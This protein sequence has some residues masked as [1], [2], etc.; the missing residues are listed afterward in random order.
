MING[1]QI[2]LIAVIISCAFNSFGYVM[3]KLAHNR[4]IETSEVSLKTWQW[5][6]AILVTVLSGVVNIGNYL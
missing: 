3:F 1:S 6:T 4:C 2:A 5:W